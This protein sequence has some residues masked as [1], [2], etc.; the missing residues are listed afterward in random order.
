ME[1]RKERRE[2]NTYRIRSE[3]HGIEVEIKGNEGMKRW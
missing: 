3:V 1:E 2:W